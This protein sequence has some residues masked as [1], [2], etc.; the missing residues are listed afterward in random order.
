M[1][2]VAALLALL[3]PPLVAGCGVHGSGVRGVRSQPTA[4]WP[5]KPHSIRVHPLTRLHDG[6]GDAMLEAWIQL[7]DRDGHPVRGLGA[8]TLTLDSSGPGD[9]R[10]L[11]WTTELESTGDT[12]LS[13]FDPV[14]HAY[15]LPLELPMKNMPPRARLR[16]TLETPDG[17]RLVARFQL[18]DA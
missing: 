18:P 1:V 8:L 11:S 15:F 3:M 4:Q 10:H 9:M 14:T 16:A 17:D 7:R 13:R 12:T 6:D 5:F 2:R